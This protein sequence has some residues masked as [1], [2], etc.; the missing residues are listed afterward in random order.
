MKIFVHQFASVY[1]NESI[2]QNSRLLTHCF[3]IQ[4]LKAQ[5]HWQKRNKFTVLDL[6][7][8][9]Q[10]DLKIILRTRKKNPVYKAEKKVLWKTAD[11]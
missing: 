10:V 11:L 4:S 2:Y 5:K 6:C 7:G 8:N 9:F 1:N 3:Q